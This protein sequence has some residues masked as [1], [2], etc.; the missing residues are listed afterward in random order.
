MSLVMILTNH[1][2]LAFF[3]SLISFSFGS[4]VVCFLSRASHMWLIM[5]AISG[6]CEPTKTRASCF[7][8][9]EAMAGKLGLHWWKKTSVKLEED[10][11]SSIAFWLVFLCSVAP[12]TYDDTAAFFGFSTA[13]K[14]LFMTA[15]ISLQSW[16]ITSKL[17]AA[18][19]SPRIKL[20][21]GQARPWTFWFSMKH[22]SKRASLISDCYRDRVF[23]L[24]D[25]LAI[26]RKLSFWQT[27]LNIVRNFTL[28][29]KTFHLMDEYYC[30]NEQKTSSFLAQILLIWMRF[31][32][33]FF[34]QN[35]RLVT[36]GMTFFWLPPPFHDLHSSREHEMNV[37][38]HSFDDRLLV[39]A[40]VCKREL[41][42]F[43]Q[44]SSQT[45]PPFVRCEYF[46]VWYTLA[47]AKV[48][49]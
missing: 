16:Q 20:K 23:Y 31:G 32:S 18:G 30:Q 12:L 13:L 2:C 47:C 37:S 24:F 21:W 1:V 17:L 48:V 6:K 14:T 25:R 15:W 41:F 43:L 26:F 34:G 49:S 42:H 44:F 22:S 40:G 11:S 28:S 9:Y 36:G 5:L 10:A 39:W 19:N 35:G 7:P 38:F 33:M 3:C 46:I 45:L 29:K 27:N 4:Q 8:S